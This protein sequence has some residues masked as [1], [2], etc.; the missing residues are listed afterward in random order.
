MAVAAGPFTTTEDLTYS[1]LSELVRVASSRRVSALVLLG[2]FVDESHPAVSSLD[3]EISFEQLFQQ[4]VIEPL[5]ELVETQLAQADEANAFV[6]H[7]VLIPSVRDVHHSPVFPQPSF[8]CNIPVAVKP[9]VHLLSNPCGFSIGGVRVAASSLDVLMLLG[10]QEL[11]KTPLAEQSASK[12]LERLPRL[13]SHLLQQGQFLPLLPVRPDEKA[14]FAVDPIA[15]FKA[16]SCGL[17]ARPD[18]LLLPSD[19]APFAK[20]TIGSVLCVNTGRLT[21]KQAGGSYASICVHPVCATETETGA[22]ATAEEK[23]MEV[24]SEAKCPAEADDAATAP[25]T[26][27]SV[28]APMSDS[29]V[30]VIARTFV[31]VARI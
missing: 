13:A 3:V 12:P 22:L 14:P 9:F 23:A 29:F 30:G 6:T 11:A 15:N 18:I 1:P 24:D 26:S 27:S 21:R 2:P 8:A 7:I 19:L 5:V 16:G 10:Q 28:T 20:E 31:E 17:T 25:C 4:R